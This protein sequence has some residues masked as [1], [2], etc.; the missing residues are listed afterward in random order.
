MH[1]FYIYTNRPALTYIHTHSMC[2]LIL[3]FSH[4]HLLLYTPTHLHTHTYRYIPPHTHTH[5][6][7]WEASHGVLQVQVLGWL[8]HSHPGAGQ[9]L[10]V[11][12]GVWR[13]GRINM[14]S[15]I[16]IHMYA[17]LHTHTHIHTYSH[18]YVPHAQCFGV[19]GVQSDLVCE[20]VTH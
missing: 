2:T 3:S 13:C 4:T 8:R 9:A 17:F 18:T 19:C 1:M 7:A 10:C 11:S 12:V 20:P 6:Y 5:T 15:F 16:H 14:H